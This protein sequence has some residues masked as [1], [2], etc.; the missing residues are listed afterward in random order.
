MAKYNEKENNVEWKKDVKMLLIWKFSTQTNKL[1]SKDQKEDN[2]KENNVE[3]IKD[4]KMQLVQQFS[5]ETSKIKHIFQTSKFDV[6]TK[7][8]CTGKELTTKDDRLLL[9]YLEAYCLVHLCICHH[10]NSQIIIY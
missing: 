10:W 6:K 5:T 2:E 8:T 9:S 4:E 7:L 1:F 3:W